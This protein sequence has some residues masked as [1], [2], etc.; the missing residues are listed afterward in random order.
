M[1]SESEG[2]GICVCA[3]PG[4][5]ELPRSCPFNLNA[6]LPC[7]CS[8]LP[9]A[10]WRGWPVGAPR[11]PGRSGGP[12]GGRLSHE[13]SFHAVMDTGQWIQANA[14][15]GECH[16]G[17]QVA[18]VMHQQIA[19]A[20]GSPVHQHP[21]DSLQRT[22]EV[23]QLRSRAPLHWQWDTW[24]RPGNA[25]RGLSCAVAAACRGAGESEELPVLGCPG[26]D[27][28]LYPARLFTRPHAF[29]CSHMSLNAWRGMRLLSG[30][31]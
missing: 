4:H 1:R 26:S 15:H 6:H 3:H 23:H 22:R 5:P 12:G 17:G 30:S 10:P 18:S 28:T 2:G 27:P 24:C 19:P 9:Q 14:P 13:K 11:M 8:P 7:P 21:G 16:P 20:G 25:V 31:S 29:T